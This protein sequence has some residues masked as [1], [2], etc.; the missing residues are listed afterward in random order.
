MSNAHDVLYPSRQR[1]H[2]LV[3]YGEYFKYMD[4]VSMRY[5]DFVCRLA[6]DDVRK[7]SVQFNLSLETFQTVWRNKR[8]AYRSGEMHR[9]PSQMW[10]RADG[11]RSL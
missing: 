11:R 2:S 4:D 10:S 7:L 3:T 8:W 5:N 1:T 6:S 9:V